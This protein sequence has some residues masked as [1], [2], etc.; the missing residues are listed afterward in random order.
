MKTADNKLN[1]KQL[2]NSS[3]LLTN[4]NMRFEQF[5]KYITLFLCLLYTKKDWKQNWDV[6]QPTLI[7]SKSTMETQEQCVK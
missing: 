2:T 3:T 4:Q 7:C 6:A 5:S 1:H